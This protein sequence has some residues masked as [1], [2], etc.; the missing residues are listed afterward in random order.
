MI[1]VLGF[2][3]FLALS[4]WDDCC[5][6]FCFW[7]PTSCLKSFPNMNT[8]CGAKKM[9][10]ERSELRH[11]FLRSA[12]Q[13]CPLQGCK[14]IFTHTLLLDAQLSTISATIKQ[15]FLKR[16]PLQP[17]N[18]PSETKPVCL[19]VACLTWFLTILPDLAPATGWELLQEWIMKG[20][21][22]I[23]NNSD[24]AGDWPLRNPGTVLEISERQVVESWLNCWC[25]I[26]DGKLSA[27]RIHR[28]ASRRVDML[29]SCKHSWQNVLPNNYSTSCQLINVSKLQFH[30]F[31]VGM[32]RMECCDYA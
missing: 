7:L 11:V 23:R 32:P 18:R 9:S 17:G 10:D 4:S 27:S 28:I 8:S 14:P 12:Q 6:P 31:C 1:V 16:L 19:T 15:K 26:Q 21:R 2:S 20:S 22:N 25:P 30:L 29:E 3:T 24:T 13:G 5:M